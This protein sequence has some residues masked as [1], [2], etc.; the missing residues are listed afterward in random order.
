MSREAC[1]QF[2]AL[3]RNHP[4]WLLLAS[5]NG[6]LTLACL[7]SVFEKHP[8]GVAQEDAI[9]QLAEA[10]ATY[11][12]DSAF[13]VGDDSDDDQAAT[14]R[15]ELRQWLKRGLIVEREGQI[16]ATDALQR[17]VAF[18]DSLQDR[19]M[20][21]TAS[22]LATVQREIENLEAR[23]NPNQASRAQFLRDKIADLEREL[24]AVERGEF[25]V[26]EGA[27]AKEG[28]REVYQ[29]ALSLLADFRRVEDSYREAD[30][31]LR[32]RIIGEKHH[33]GE[34]VDELLEGNDALVN[35]PEGQV[36]EGFHQQLVQTAELERMKERLR[37]ILDNEATGTALE[38]KQKADLRQL[39]SRLV[40]ESERVIQA[41]ARSERDVRGF[42][43]SGLA[44]EHLRVGA[45]LQDLLQVALEVDWQ[46]QKVRRTPGP[47]PPV[48]IAIP[49][50]PVIER[51]LVKDATTKQE[52][53][54]DLSVSSADP[55]L[56]DDE[57]WHAYR[58]LDRAALFQSTID[59]LQASGRPLTIGELAAALPPS[60][61][62]ETLS[63]W[64]A[65]AR[66]CGIEITGAEETIDLPNDQGDGNGWTRFTTPRVELT[67]AG[68][69]E[70]DAGKME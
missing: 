53:E 42:L 6:P 37:S 56:M 29:L 62:L 7:K 63:Y 25:E 60:H 2:I 3:R 4:A 49:G 5:R 10:F 20:T 54:L 1:Q 26:L 17:S 23:L 32:Q 50:L 65:M 43:K 8:G 21:S 52:D 31:A 64:L 69:A 45:I 11:A 38:R 13:D 46:S 67:H 55:T 57:F 33:R 12:N 58:S 36:F 35:T 16:M 18:L 34:I 39:V 9:A 22:R 44:D 40:Q 15:K 59:H 68:V 51:L 19:G 24:A 61:D 66:E 30:R 14:A 27:Q 70:L 48:A 47:L 41:R 28:I